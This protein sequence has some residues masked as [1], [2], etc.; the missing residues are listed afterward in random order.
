[1]PKHLLLIQMA[2]FHICRKRFRCLSTGIYCHFKYLRAS[3]T[4]C[5]YRTGHIVPFGTNSQGW[6]CSTK[7]GTILSRIGVEV[8]LGQDNPLLFPVR[9][10]GHQ[11]GNSRVF[12][13]PEKE[14]Q[15]ADGLQ[16]S[17][18]IKSWNRFGIGDWNLRFLLAVRSGIPAVALGV[19]AWTTHTPMCLCNSNLSC[20]R[21]TTGRLPV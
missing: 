1:M 21:H 15:E 13:G 9:L 19:T 14:K 20:G 5:R 6:R 11:P 3:K 10:A 2:K 18:W 12:I 8:G 17:Q 7:K 16:R 4:S